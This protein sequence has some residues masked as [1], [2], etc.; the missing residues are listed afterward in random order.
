MP[1][2]V[3]RLSRNVKRKRWAVVGLCLS[4]V[5]LVTL[6]GL[7]VYTV[8]TAHDQEKMSDGYRQELNT[9]NKELDA[10]RSR[11]SQQQQELESL[12]KE[13]DNATSQIQQ[14]EKELWEQAQELEQ[15]D[16]TI[17]SLK[18]RI[19]LKAAGKPTPTTTTLNKNLPYRDY[20]DLKGKKLVALTF[21]DGPGPYTERLLDAMKKRGVKATFFVLGQRVD[22][23]G[24]LIKRMEKEGHV[25]GSHSYDHPNLTKLSYAKVRDNME[26]TA[27]KIEKLIGHKPEIMR[28]PGGSCNDTVK[29]YA[30]EAGIPIAFWGVDTRDWESRNVKKI[31]SV[32]FG[33][34]GIKDGSI[35]LMHDIYETTVDASIQMMDRLLKEGY[36]FVTMPELLMARY[37]KI[38]PGKVYS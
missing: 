22:K 9:L 38:T 26:K 12:Q 37:G 33:K 4:L 14:H 32:S 30:K 15:K 13:L 7:T 35:V 2:T 27:K 17:K 19:S 28:C 6:G 29:K 31:L 24:D 16:E 1:R 23:Y 5:L 18:T 21:D 20:T 25:V 11:Q 36:V 34:D 3:Y 10:A 8:K